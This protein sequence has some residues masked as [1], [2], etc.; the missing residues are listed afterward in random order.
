MSQRRDF[1]YYM[2]LPYKIELYPA[3][4]GGFVAAAQTIEADGGAL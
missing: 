2:S 1:E 3:K 4:E